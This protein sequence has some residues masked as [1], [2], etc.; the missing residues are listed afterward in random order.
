MLRSVFSIKNIFAL[1]ITLCFAYGVWEARSYEF[2]AKVFP[3]Y[4]SILL[5][6]CAI[7]NLIQEAWASLHPSET[8]NVS[9]SDLST[10]WTIPMK[11]VW[12]RFFFYLVVLLVL[13]GFIWILGYPLA[14]MLFV[15]FFYLF[16]ARASWRASAIAGLGA[17]VFLAVTS[18]VLSMVWPEGLIHLP[19]PLG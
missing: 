18:N 19:W 2:L 6:I 4:I 5:L 12:K 11:E 16:M 15:F 13:Y 8:N 9:F 10:S 1:F 14:M 3:F 17:L 7:I